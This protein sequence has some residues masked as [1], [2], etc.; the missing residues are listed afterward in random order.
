MRT[1]LP[2]SCAAALSAFAL[3]APGLARA[4]PPKAPPP[5][6]ASASADFR[7]SKVLGAGQTVS[8]RNIRGSIRAEP[9]SSNALE[10][11]ATKVSEGGDPALVRV[12]A[13]EGARGVTVCA[14]YP[15]SG[16]TCDGGQRSSGHQDPKVRV[17]FVVRVPAGLVFEAA[18]VSGNIEAR[19][20][21]N[22][23]RATA[24][25]GTVDVTTSSGAVDARSVSGAVRVTMGAPRE[26][27]ASTAS[28]V[29]GD[30]EVKL[31]AQSSFDADATTVSGRIDTD[32]GLPVQRGFVGQNLH[33]RVGKGGA[34]LKLET[35]SGGIRL[36]RS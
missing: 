1:I 4:E 25:S 10:V 6:G 2:T 14:L 7:Y 31:P 30:V 3:F 8:I 34:R 22:D 15:G 23:V 26:G 29:S 18:S 9:S 27:A 36:S 32:F 16:D 17:E 20:L 11:V 21:R 13:N 5:A 28:A 24:V 12:V 19:G 33:G 35:V